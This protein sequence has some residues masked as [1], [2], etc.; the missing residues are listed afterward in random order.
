MV[1]APFLR[2]FIPAVL[3]YYGIRLILL[4]IYLL[5]ITALTVSI[6]SLICGFSLSLSSNKKLPVIL[7]ITA[8]VFF[9]C[10]LT[11]LLAW[12]LKDVIDQKTA[13]LGGIILIIVGVLNIVRKKD[14]SLKGDKVFTKSLVTGFAVGLDGALATLSLS[15][16]YH[17]FIIPAVISLTHAVTISIGVYLAKVKLVRKIA[18]IEFI[19]SLILILLGG[20]KLLGFFI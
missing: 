14:S 17:T 19:P 5:I 7:G 13:N 12:A 11:Y 9:L 1:F 8:V 3:I 15:L 18:K 16:I 20:Y 4:M 6:D 2:T 10:C